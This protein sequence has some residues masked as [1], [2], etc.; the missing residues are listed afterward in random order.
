MPIEDLKHQI[1]RLPEQP[2]VYV[3]LDAGGATLYVGKA[4]HLR[5]RVGS[6]L[7][8]RGMSPRHDLLLDGAARLDAIVTDSVGEALMLEA[9]LIKQR[10][11]RFNIMLRDDKH[12]PFLMLT[13]AE[14]CP[15]VLVARR[16]ER[17]GNVYAGPYMPS[18]LAR[19]TMQLT[20]RVLGI[21]SCNEKIDG[22]RDRPCLEYDIGR[23]LAPCVAS[24]C[25]P[26]AYAAAVARTRLLLEGR[27]GELVEQLTTEMTAAAEGESYE[28]AAH[29]R[30]GIGTLE[31]LRGRQQK[32]ATPTAGDRDAFGLKT[33]PSGLVLQVF[34]VRRGRVIDRVELV[35]DADSAGA[36]EADVVGA[37]ISQ[38]YAHR[39]V[40]PEI[41]VGQLPEDRDALEAW[42]SARAGRHVS[43][44][45][46]RGQDRRGLLDLATR[47]ASM[48]Y[49]SRFS[50]G[51]AANYEALE[52]LREILGLAAFPRRIECFDIS[53]LQGAQTVASMVVCE[54]GRMRKSDY[55]KYR[56]RSAVGEGGE[57]KHDDCAAMHEVVQ[58]RYQ[59]V[60]ALGGPFPDL[61]VIDGGRGQLEAAYAALELLGLAN[62]VAVGLA[63]REEL[64]VTRDRPD[65]IALPVNHPSLLLLERIRDEAHRFAVTFHRRARTSRDLRSELDDIRG[66]GPRRRR[67]LLQAFGSLSGVRRASREDLTAVVGTKAADAVLSHFARES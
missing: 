1:S 3:F 17:D 66:I 43:I 8:A 39:E 32:M 38:F 30:D 14:P 22:R 59:K 55:R 41:H 21:R 50:G 67:A 64:V 58:R 49:Q 24:I 48:A 18:S 44:V 12:Y 26:D 11:P 29:L 19:R 7:N 25:S 13:V 10:H 65:P 4:A 52:Q 37:A 16:V 61:I 23:C 63:K 56:V 9:N 20:H 46:P 2:G 62:L 15:R 34:L 27:T 51:A 54:D 45:V 33:G 31:A 35:A 6:Y 28:Q 47:N 5:D 53:T 42:L 40:P 60:L 57:E 36:P